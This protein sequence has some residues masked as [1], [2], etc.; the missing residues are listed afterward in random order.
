MEG[1]SLQ[2]EEQTVHFRLS[3]LFNPIILFCIF[4]SEVIINKSLAEG[5]FFCYVPLRLGNLL[6]LL[7]FLMRCIMFSIVSCIMIIKSFLI[8]SYLKTSGLA[9]QSTCLG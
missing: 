6:S 1:C 7:Q 3:T 5:N 2:D 4:L 9:V 8:T